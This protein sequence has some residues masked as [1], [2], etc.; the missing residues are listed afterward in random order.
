MLSKLSDDSDYLFQQTDVDFKSVSES[1]EDDIAWKKDYDD[2]VARALPAIVFHRAWRSFSNLFKQGCLVDGQTTWYNGR[3][4]WN[5]AG[6]P[7][8]WVD[9]QN[10]YFS[11]CPRLDEDLTIYT[12]AAPN[13][14]RRVLCSSYHV[15]PVPDFSAVQEEVKRLATAP[16]CALTP[17]NIDAVVLAP[18]VVIDLFKRIL[19]AFAMNPVGFETFDRFF[20]KPG[21]LKEDLILNPKLRLSCNA[22]H[23]SFRH[24]CSPLD[25]QGRLTQPVTLVDQG[26]AAGLVASESDAK[27]VKNGAKKARA[28]VL[29]ELINRTKPNGHAMTPEGDSC[30]FYPV[31]ESNTA[32]TLPDYGCGF[33]RYIAERTLVIESM[34]FVEPADTSLS[35]FIYLPEGGILYENGIPIGVTPPQKL[36]ATLPDLLIQALPATRSIDFAGFVLCCLAFDA[37]LVL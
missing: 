25:A 29:D 30:V 12:E 37:K 21:S 27:R 3:Q 19:P 28:S 34:R 5:G 23:S 24:N 36:S 18:N 22:L 11:L 13:R 10:V 35:P 9:A 20:A 17:S 15:D 6:L 26:H 1:I 33:T 8:G 2:E 16:L 14:R 4:A 7:I 32:D 31:L